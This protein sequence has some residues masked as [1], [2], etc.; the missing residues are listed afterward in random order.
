MIRSLTL[1]LLSA[2]FTWA[3]PKDPPVEQQPTDDKA[4]KV[5]L[6][7]GSGYFKAGEHDYLAGCAVLHDLLKQTP[8]VAPVF[9]KDWP[10]NPETLKGA[11]TIVILFDGGDKHGFL[12]ENRL[13]EIQKLAESGVGL[14]A[15]HQGV[16]VSK[17]LGER[18]RGLFGAAWEK[19]YSARAHWIG[20]FSKFPDHPIARGVTPF[21]IDDGWLFK[22]RFVP[23]LKGVTPL[24]KTVS[25]KAPAESIQSNEAT[26]GW[27]YERA[28]KGR[29]FCFTGCHL[30]DS[31]AQEGYR[32][33]LVNG[34]LW[35]AGLEVPAE[36]APVALNPSDLKGYLQS[37]PVKKK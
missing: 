11:R 29:S 7:A 9:V 3:G 25:P 20:E 35:S 37:A 27:A 28:G 5:V 4:A 6:I 33:F 1:L 31:L 21:K 12:K 22:L 19:G 32:R 10:Q 30:H 24:V 8:G 18:F 17:D 34:I 13:A 36:G 23:D 2:S 14:V 15:L 26:V 16:D